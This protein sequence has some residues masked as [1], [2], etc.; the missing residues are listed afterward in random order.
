[1]ATKSD[2]SLAPHGFYCPS[3][4][5]KRAKECELLLEQRQLNIERNLW[6]AYRG[7]WKHYTYAAGWA[8]LLR[9]EGEDCP[10]CG[11]LLNDNRTTTPNPSA[12]V[13]DHMDPTSLGGED[14]LRNAIYCCSRCNS[15]KKDKP[16]LRWL[17]ELSEPYRTLCRAIYIFKHEHNPEDFESGFI[18]SRCEGIPM[19]LEYG[20]AEFK[21]EMRGMLPLAK[22]PPAPYLVDLLRP[23]SGPVE[24]ETLIYRRSSSKP[25]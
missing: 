9:T 19:F 4:G 6:A 12:A 13:I 18:G 14:S 24:I 10:Y 3:C 8:S 21:R 25:A 11:C 22:T 1:M 2:G 7:W 20:E 16:F 17:T 23:H 5:N 15:R